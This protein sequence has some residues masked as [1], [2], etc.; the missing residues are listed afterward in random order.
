MRRNVNAVKKKVIGKPCEGEPH[1]RFDEGEQKTGRFIS[2]LRLFSTLQLKLIIL[3]IVVM[4][5]CK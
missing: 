4:D 2:L 5:N 1:A 3:I